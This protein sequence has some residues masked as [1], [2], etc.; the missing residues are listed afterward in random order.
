MVLV[1]CS[2]PSS[3]QFGARLS[4]ISFLFLVCM[5]V[6]VCECVRLLL[7][8]LR[9]GGEGG[10]KWMVQGRSVGCG[11]EKKKCFLSS[12]PFLPPF[13][14]SWWKSA[15]SVPCK[16]EEE[17]EEEEDSHGSFLE[18]DGVGRGRKRTGSGGNRRKKAM[19]KRRRDR[20]VL[21]PFYMIVPCTLTKTIRDRHRGF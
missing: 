19:R 8:N 3:V 15:A 16:E 18:R 14:P 11:C 20:T 5:C 4:T 2:L 13:G 6:C 12:L 10:E 7:S 1:A 17:E 9:G 21:F